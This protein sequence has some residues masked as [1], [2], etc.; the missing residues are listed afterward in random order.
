MIADKLLSCLDG[1][2][3][4]GSDRWVA[5]CPSHEDKTPSLAISEADERVLVHCFGGCDV[6]SVMS[7]VG[8]TLSDLFPESIKSHRSE[9]RPIPA[10]D[11]LRCIR[12]DSTFIL[13]CANAIA[14][15]MELNEKEFELLA[16]ARL[17]IQAAVKAGGI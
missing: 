11:I 17:R 3:Q 13:L 10:T 4:T 2:K 8:L 16:Q 9:R 14:G 6:E 12:D 5:K 1:V 7:S 15:N